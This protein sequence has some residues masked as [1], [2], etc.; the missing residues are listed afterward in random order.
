MDDWE[1]VTKDQRL[2]P[3]PRQPSVSQ[4]LIDYRMSVPM[5]RPGSAEAEIFEETLLGLQTY[6]DKCLGTILLYRFERQ[7]YADIRK[8]HGEDA[9]MSDIYGAEHLLR[10]FGLTQEYVQR[11]VVL[12]C[13]VSMQELVGLTQMDPQAVDV[14]RSHL[15]DLMRFDLTACQDGVC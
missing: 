13:A 10:L 6:F 4:I 9:K 14:L 11:L 5:K 7:Q 1:W 2:A 15:Q 8:K 3:L 12:I